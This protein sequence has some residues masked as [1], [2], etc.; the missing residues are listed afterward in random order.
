MSLSFINVHSFQIYSTAAFFHLTLMNSAK[1]QCHQDIQIQ[2]VHLPP[3]QPVGAVQ[4]ARQHL[5]SPAHG[6][7]GR[8]FTFWERL[9]I[10]PLQTK[11]NKGF[12]T[13]YSC[14]SVQQT[15][16]Q[17]SSLP[18]FTTAVPVLF[19]LSI[20]AVKDASDDIVR[21]KSSKNVCQKE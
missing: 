2:R 15:I 3:A 18:W 16:P 17:V 4:K 1:E 5:L 8:Y 7:S 20:T 13:F 11:S 10:N 6:P 19:M 14:V 12:L 9:M 21:K